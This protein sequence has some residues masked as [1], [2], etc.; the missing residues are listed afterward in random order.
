MRILLIKP[1]LSPSTLTGGNYL[2]LE[3]LELEHLAAG[4]PDHDVELID[5]RFE[6]DLESRICTFQ[7]HIVGST[8]YSVHV[9]NTL[10]ISSATN[11]MRLK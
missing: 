2:E 4:L 3:P 7:P 11:D 9:Y 10:R 8:A 6:K 5:M 1:Y